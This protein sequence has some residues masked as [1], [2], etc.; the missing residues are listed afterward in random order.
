MES[1]YDFCCPVTN[2]VP[3]SGRLSHETQSDLSLCSVVV[4][5]V[6]HGAAQWTPVITPQGETIVTPYRGALRRRAYVALRSTRE[7]ATTV[8]GLAPARS[9]LSSY[10]SF[11]FSAAVARGFFF[12]PRATDRTAT[13]AYCPHRKRK[14]TAPAAMVDPP[15]PPPYW[16]NPPPKELW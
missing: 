15:T 7:P 10:L 11:N 2:S 6:V 12:A 13:G 3:P 9:G 5:V 16:L 4:P 14:F 1:A 8:A